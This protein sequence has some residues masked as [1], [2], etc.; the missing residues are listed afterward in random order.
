MFSI[1]SLVRFAH[2]LAAVLLVGAQLSLSLVVRP[3]AANTLDDNTRSAFFIRVGRIFGRLSSFV[4]FP[5]LLGTGLGLMYHRGVDIGALAV[6]RYGQI[7]T[8]KIVLAFV[9]FGLAVVH[10]V[11][12]GRAT[13]GL[14]GPWESQ[15]G[16]SQRRSFSWLPP[17]SLTHQ[18]GRYE[19]RNRGPSPPSPQ[20]APQL[21]EGQLVVVEPGRPFSP[22]WRHLASAM[23]S[24]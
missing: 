10:G 20:T 13:Q 14:P 24:D 5:V 12:P 11:M 15:A 1:W 7:L 16:W 23:G 18:S 2:V 8:V 19:L 21:Q 3:A 4:L 9:S 17:S 6:G 22:A